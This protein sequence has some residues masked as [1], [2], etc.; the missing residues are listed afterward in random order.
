MTEW[1]VTLVSAESVQANPFRTMDTPVMTEWVL[2]ERALR[3]RRASSL[4]VGL[5]NCTQEVGTVG[6]VS[7]GSATTVSLPIIHLPGCRL[8]TAMAFASASLLAVS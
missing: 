1:K 8:E 4:S 3:I 2:P 7:I 6:G 5:E